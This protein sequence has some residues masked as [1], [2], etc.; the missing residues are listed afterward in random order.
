[1]T[2]PTDSAR[3]LSRGLVAL[4]LVSLALITLASPGATRMSA[5]PWSC[6][7]LFA[8]SVPPLLL[9][10]RLFDSRQP[11]VPPAPAWCATVLLAALAILLS[12]LAS[13]WRS[14]SLLWS[15]PLLSALAL[16]FVAHDE[17]NSAPAGREA[18]LHRLLT[19]SGLFFATVAITSCLLWSRGLDA[20]W[21]EQLFTA[22]NPFPLGH[23]NYTAG[24]A[25]LMLP[26]FGALARA[27]SGPR[28]AAWLF[29]ALLALGLLFTSGSRG[30]LIGLVALAFVHVPAVARALKL[31]LWLIGLSALVALAALFYFNPRTR[32]FLT[33]ERAA[34]VLRESNAQR[35]IL[36]AAG[37]ELARE[38][39]LLGWGAG[40]TPLA[41]PRVRHRLDGGVENVLQLHNTPLQLSADF[42]ALGALATLALFALALRAAF[43]SPAA[44]AVFLAL[45]GYA[46]FSLTDWQLD[47][48]IFACALALAAAAIAPAAD[49]PSRKFLLP[50]QITLL[51]SCALLAAFARRDPTPALNIRALALARDPA[52]ADSAIAL[53][54]ASLA[55]NP[56]QEIAHF[57]L[58]W[59]LVT[60][61]PA[62][63]E[64]H[65]LA[66][67]HLVPDQGGVYFGLALARLNQ[68][69]R[70]A[71]TRALALECLNDPLFLTSPW[72]RL[73]A[74]AELRA[75]TFALAATLL[76]PLTLSRPVASEALYLT[77]LIA[78]LDDRAAPGEMLAASHTSERV[79]YFA[80]RPVRP[81]FA[82]APL[83]SYRRERTTYPVLMRNLDLPSPTDLFDAQ[84][85]QLAV[86]ELNFLFPRKGWLPAPLL[87][88]L[89]DDPA[90][91]NRESKI[92]NRK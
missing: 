62:A 32:A 6:A 44:R 77:A 80:R 19:G 33:G 73:P 38:R 60:R 57:N 12:G 58:G 35:S 55:L 92:G 48:P 52:Q 28:R 40:S 45:V 46:M 15:A 25:L 86:T 17:L 5:A 84:E 29:A 85:N 22:R 4:G 43:T 56:D 88:P 50:L 7:Y 59:L 91:L 13:P 54:R 63:A 78:W 23:S 61:D 41:Y 87:L 36:L 21:R 47:V 8:C 74:F 89:L 76:H 67:A 2:R 16:F 64:R 69:Q 9:A 1:M 83:R 26:V 70:P 53:L 24:L 3:L 31:R 34:A 75:D 90:P 39:P 72:W 71:A 20:R 51:A 49:T 42:G 10:L 79:G 66:A 14:P 68:G 81:D 18:R 30:G 65:F 82:A 27:N 11:F 37:A